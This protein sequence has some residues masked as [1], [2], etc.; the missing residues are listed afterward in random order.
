MNREHQFTNNFVL[1]YIIYTTVI[2]SGLVAIQEILKPGDV[3]LFKENGPIEWFEFSLVTLASLTLAVGAMII[4]PLR[5][6]LAVLSCVVSIA[7]IRELDG[8]LD[9]KL[10][11]SWKGPMLLGVALTVYIG[12]SHRRKLGSQIDYFS[13]TASFGIL[14]AGF[15]IV[16]LLAQLIGHGAFL[17]KVMGDDYQHQYKRVIEEIFEMFGYLII[18]FGSL[19]AVIS[20]CAARRKVFQ[21]ILMQD[22]EIPAD[23]QTTAS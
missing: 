17:E 3:M 14:W 16:V 10:P 19:E 21:D 15:V 5:G 20:D 7:A 23:A 6:L 2:L 9:D 11:F 12:F 1:R 18:L 13:K 4:R 8:L 22:I